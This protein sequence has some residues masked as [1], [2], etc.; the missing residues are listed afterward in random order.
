[1]FSPALFRFLRRGVRGT[2]APCFGDRAAPEALCTKLMG[3]GFLGGVAGL[4]L[5]VDLLTLGGITLFVIGLLIA[6]LEAI[7]G[8][9]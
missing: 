9:D 7:L 5:G 6:V 1:M 8:L 3:V 2:Q 4:Y